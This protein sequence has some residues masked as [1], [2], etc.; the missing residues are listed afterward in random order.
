MNRPV[1]T[2]RRYQKPGAVCVVISLHFTRKMTLDDDGVRVGDIVVIVDRIDVER[3]F[4]L[5][6]DG[7]LK[8][9]YSSELQS[10]LYK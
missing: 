3:R 8:I 10:Q 5:T 1:G 7:T 9:F 2:G 4:C 6:S